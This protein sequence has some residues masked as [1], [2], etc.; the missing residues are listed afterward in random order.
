M[1]FFDQIYS[2]LFDTDKA[3]Q[4][5][6]VIENVLKRNESFIQNYH[7]WKVSDA[8]DDLIGDILNAYKHTLKGHEETPSMLLHQSAN[9]NGFAVSFSDKY[10]QYSYQYLLDYLAERVKN[11]GYRPAMS[12]HTLKENGSLVET[13][14]MRYLKPKFGHVEPIDQ[15]FG[16]I[17]IEY[18]AFNDEPS[19]LKFVANTYS[20]RKYT[21]ALSFESLIEKVLSEN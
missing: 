15:K 17:Q 11:L 4:Q 14:E 7:S 13:K 18:V 5:P 12:R 20:D 8:A 21:K 1:K 19:R 3:K 10:E 6:V 16:N 9:S 2:R